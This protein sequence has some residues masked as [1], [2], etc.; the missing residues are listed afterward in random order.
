MGSRRGA[1][2]T[3]FAAAGGVY[4]IVVTGRQLDPGVGAVTGNYTLRI[5]KAA[6]LTVPV[7]VAPVEAPVLSRLALYRPASVTPSVND[8]Q[9]PDRDRCRGPTGNT[10]SDSPR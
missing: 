7:D 2:Y 3:F 10:T 5:R 4:R 6:P 9:P 1:G 8:W